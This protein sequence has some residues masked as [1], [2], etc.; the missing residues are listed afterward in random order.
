MTSNFIKT[1]L[2]FSCIALLLAV[3]A[4]GEEESLCEKTYRKIGKA[5]SNILSPDCEVKV[6]AYD[7]L[8]DLYDKG[9]DCK[10][11]KQRVWDGG[12]DTVDQFIDMLEEARADVIADCAP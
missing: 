10:P 6:S 7:Q 3:S 5:T 11:I 4:C 8:I 9:R 1:C 12:Y 2:A